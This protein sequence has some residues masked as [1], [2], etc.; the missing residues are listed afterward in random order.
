MADNIEDNLD[1]KTKKIRFED[2]LKSSDT[3]EWWDIHFN[4]PIGFFWAKCAI[5]L[6]ITPNMITIASI[7]IGAVGGW[8][9]YY[10]DFKLNIIG[11][12]LL[13]LANTFDSADGQLARL[14]GN[15]TRL[16]RI[17]D[18]LAGDI[19][20]FVIYLALVLRLT[21]LEGYSVWAMWLLAI[22]AGVSHVLAASMADYYRN[23][24]LFLL[25][26]ESGSEHDKSDKIK[27]DFKEIKFSKQPFAKVSMWFYYR[28]TLT[29]ECLSP[30]L[31]AF[32]ATV[33]RMYGDKMPVDLREELREKNK[34][35]MPLTNILQFN[36]RV[37]F[38]F[39]TLLISQVWLYFVFDVTV[40]NLIL[41]YLIRKEEQLF[42]SYDKE[43]HQIEKAKQKR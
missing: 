3:E 23:V 37:M 39:F 7:F 19:W 18:G 29:Q 4:R 33:K 11:M 14:T 22:A 38:L 16:G 28:Y 10:T 26:G 8:L 40:M 6:H 43:L 17:L 31:Q 35:Y 2:S 5:P 20:F 34:K 41:I 9:F 25:K 27:S 1:S 42:F 30:K 12:V 32:S 36:T 15:K 24:H 13:V 21:L